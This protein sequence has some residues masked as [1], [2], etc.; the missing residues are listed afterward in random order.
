MGHRAN[1]PGGRS[2]S[3]PAGR[4]DAPE[5]VP[6][7]A[8][9]VLA[10]QRAAGNVAT[11]HLLARDTTA[12][13]T[14]PASKTPVPATPTFRLLVGDNGKHGLSEAVVEEALKG[15]RAELERIMKV[16]TD[17]KVKAG[18]EIQYVK[19]RRPEGND[20]F[21]PHLGKS[22][23]LIFLTKAKDAKG[24]I[25]IL[26]D[27]IPED[28]STRKAREQRFRQSMAGEGGVDL[29]TIHNIKRRD[30]QSVG[31]VGTD[32]PIAELKKHGQASAAAV[33]ADVM[34]HEIGHA[35]GHVKPL[36]SMDHDDSGI[37]T[38]QLARDAGPHKLRQY[39]SAS[40]TI[41]RSRLEELS[42]RIKPKP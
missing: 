1:A 18:F 9:G 19:D 5:G 27:Y 23:F 11:R 39:S 4:S 35:L 42:K 22:T 15:V 25:E 21:T 17:P 24:A 31:F 34:L 7:L 6:P 12:T 20:D 26:W 29:Q 13:K 32:S 2:R 40:A 14:P 41:I 38:A 3:R 28:V 33:L 10:L 36:A 30:S 37:M 16:S 8:L